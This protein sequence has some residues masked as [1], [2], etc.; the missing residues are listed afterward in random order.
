M[1]T[2]AM[3]WEDD[4]KLTRNARSTSDPRARSAYLDAKAEGGTKE[5]PGRAVERGTRKKAPPA[6]LGTTTS[7][8]GAQ[9][10]S[11]LAE[12]SKCTTSSEG[13]DTTMAV[14]A[15]EQ[16]ERPKAD[17]R[18]AAAAL[19]GHH[20]HVV[21]GRHA[22]CRPLPKGQAATKPS[23]MC[24]SRHRFA[25]VCVGGFINDHSTGTKDGPG[26]ET[27]RGRGA[28]SE[29]SSSTSARP[30]TPR[31]SST[32]RGRSGTARETSRGLPGEG[33]QYGGARSGTGR[34]SGCMKRLFVFHS[35]TRTE[36]VGWCVVVR[37]DAAHHN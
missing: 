22:G 28:A 33:I 17:A 6:D 4:G 32:T 23:S 34:V 3:E 29:A 11:M 31:P 7:I 2:M 5:G 24:E 37:K 18:P 14:P 26:R 27:T 16:A 25:C 1:A 15:E 21:C 19:Y 13:V 12:V 30:L 10:G 9:T 20:Q 36:L 35:L 8:D